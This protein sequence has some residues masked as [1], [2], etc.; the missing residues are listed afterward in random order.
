ML[1][2]FTIILQYFAEYKYFTGT[3]GGRNCSVHK[4]YFF[5]RVMTFHYYTQLFFSPSLGLVNSQN[6]VRVG[7]VPL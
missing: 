5:K 7:Y 1:S 3:I 4:E 6:L 2:Y